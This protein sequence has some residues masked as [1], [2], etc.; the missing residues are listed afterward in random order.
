MYVLAL[1]TLLAFQSAPEVKDLSWLSGRWTGSMGRA[2]IEESWTDNKGGAMLAV[3]RTIVGDRLVMFEFL[4]IVKKTD[5]VYYV[6]QP[7]G[8]PPVEFKLTK[9][10]PGLAVFENPQHDH[11]KIITYKLEGA[12]ALI[13]II[14]GDE[15]GQHKKQEFRFERQAN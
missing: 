2:A 10:E 7:G 12:T 3:S 11:P 4:R 15:K 6:A 5:G 1:F 8:R 13:A 9:Y 14:E